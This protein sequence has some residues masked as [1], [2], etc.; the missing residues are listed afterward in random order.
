MRKVIFLYSGEGTRS[1]ETNFTLAKTSPCWTEINTIVKETLNLSLEE[2]CE[3]ADI[4]RCPH[5]PLV[6]VA[7][8][9]CLA[10]IWQCWGYRPDVVIGHSIGELAASYQ[11]GL[12]NLEEI[13]LLTHRIGTIAGSID[14]LMAHGL[15]SEEEVRSLSVSLSSRNFRVD[16]KIHV[17]ISGS[18]SEIKQFINEHD[19]FVEMKPPHPW[20]N[21][22]YENYSAELKQ[23]ASR[24]TS[25]T[26]FVSGVTAR[27][28]SCLTP[29]HWRNWISQPID[30]IGSMGVIKE[31][32]AADELQVI[33]I[34]FHPVL[35]KCCEILENYAYCSS[36]FRGE[37]ELSWIFYQ[38]K[39]CMPENFL[40][41]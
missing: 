41:D 2:M 4:H 6:T 37:N 12:Y 29:S 10:D 14:G 11:A 33:E 32:C 9:I 16:D 20:H 7:T 26:I 35:E 19:G 13:I 1:R 17:T 38:R 5:S 39:R 28:E 27:V 21:A 22:K 34:G 25:D 30:F 18:K 36:M 3:A 40:T 24:D 23:G 15:L 31:K 8:Q